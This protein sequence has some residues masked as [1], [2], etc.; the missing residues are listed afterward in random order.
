MVYMMSNVPK[1]DILL[2]SAQGWIAQPRRGVRG[3]EGE[4]VKSPG[5]TPGP[6]QTNRQRH[7]QGKTYT[8]SLRRL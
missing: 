4:G 5:Q 7:T 3:R 8:S 1:T 6:G 2:E